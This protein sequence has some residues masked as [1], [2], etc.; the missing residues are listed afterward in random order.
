VMS[1]QP[2][3]RTPVPQRT[4]TAPAVLPTAEA[5]SCT[6]EMKTPRSSRP[7]SES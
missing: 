3:R 5:G 4:A 6:E 2:A 1:R 7:G